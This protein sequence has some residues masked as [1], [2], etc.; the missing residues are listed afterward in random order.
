MKTFNSYTTSLEQCSCPSVL[1]LWERVD[2]ILA[3][4][5]DSSNRRALIYMTV[6]Q[7]ATALASRRKECTELLLLLAVRPPLNESTGD[8]YGNFIR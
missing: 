7:I 5:E 3:I 8:S 1:S 4:D 2:K 6:N